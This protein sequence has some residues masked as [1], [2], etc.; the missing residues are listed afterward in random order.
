MGDP[1]KTRKQFKRPLT[2]WNTASIAREKVLKETFGLKNKREIWKTETN[3]RKK[4]HSA[5]SLLA[6]PLEKRLKREKELIGSLSRMGI[7]SENAGLDDVLTLT[8]ESF[9]ERRLQTMTWRKGLANTAIQARQFVTHGH[10]AIGGKR[11]TA[12]SYMVTAEDEGKIS[13]YAGKKMILA[14]VIKEAKKDGKKKTIKEEFE[15]AKPAEAP[16][17]AAIDVMKA[18]KEAREKEL[19]KTKKKKDGEEKPAEKP[20][21]KKKDAKKE[22]PAEK[23]KD[24]KKEKPAKEAKTAEVKKEVKK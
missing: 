10:I 9:L 11:V 5:R 8:I 21:E 16:N 20:A 1:R 12:P 19:A 18:V 22:K 4:R 6:L 2:I 3:L 13:Y 15:A 17:E 7:L 14:P 24:A 23:K